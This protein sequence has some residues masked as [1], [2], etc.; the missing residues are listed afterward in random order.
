MTDGA[1]DD[2]F[3]HTPNREESITCLQLYRYRLSLAFLLTGDFKALF[4]P[5]S[6][7]LIWR[8]T[9]QGR[10]QVNGLQS[11]PLYFKQIR[12]EYF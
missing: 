8:Q 2:F 10:L 9:M 1:I 3:A 12:H 4:S 5:F 11:S 6:I 7:A